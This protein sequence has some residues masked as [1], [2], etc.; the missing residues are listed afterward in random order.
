MTIYLDII[1]LENL[2]MNYIILYATTIITKTSPKPIRLFIGSLIGAIYAIVVV[3]NILEIYSNIVFKILVSIV[4][5]YVSLETKNAKM[6]IKDLLIFYLT[7]FTFGGVT[8]A[9]IYFIK[10]E[11]I[12]MKNGVYIGT[13]PIKMLL[14]GGILGYIIITIAFSI[15]KKKINRS[16]T[17]CNIEVAINNK[18][19]DIKALLDTGNFLKEPITG[20]PVV[21]AENK[22]LEQILPEGIMENIK[23]II[24]GRTELDSK[25]Y[26][27][28]PKMRVIPF[29]S[30]G[31]QHGM[32]L[33]IKADYIK[34]FTQDEEYKITNVIV[35]IY[36]GTLTK[37]GAYNSLISLELLERSET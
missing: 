9:L 3:L 29:S 37:D 20:T 17:Y 31:K 13:Y 4:M 16:A 7:S 27:L 10:P 24:D 6:L 32:L 19:A 30:L 34:V 21:I 26:E 15:I 28:L 14:L 23:P 2:C 1:F 18:I 22:V 5:V 8:L 33:G 35:A 11:N 25:L 12:I 36:E